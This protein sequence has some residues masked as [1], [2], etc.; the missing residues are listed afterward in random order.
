LRYETLYAEW[1]LP[2]TL[3][4]DADPAQ[5]RHAVITHER[6]VI[7]YARIRL[8]E[9]DAKILQV[10]TSPEF[11]G[12]GIATALM[13]ELMHVA[14]EA[15]RTHVY[16]DARE[17]VIG[18]YEKLGFEGEGEVFLSSRTGTPHRVMRYVFE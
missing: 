12:R 15:G 7:G 13:A 10:C 8:V 4:E 16:L 1:G 6:C 11:R 3:V 14:R 9:D 18:Y 2:R 5:Y 17:H